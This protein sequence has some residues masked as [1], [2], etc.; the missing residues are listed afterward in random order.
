[1]NGH[2]GVCPVTGAGLANHVEGRHVKPNLKVKVPQPIKLRNHLVDEEN[3]DLLHSHQ[4]DLGGYVK[5]HTLSVDRF[6]PFFLYFLLES[7]QLLAVEIRVDS[8]F[9][10]VK[11]HNNNA[12][13]I[14]PYT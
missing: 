7:H 6:R 5:N 3:Y 8:F 1:M 12:F 10:A 4:E 9:P 2:A 11:A 14:P 13:P